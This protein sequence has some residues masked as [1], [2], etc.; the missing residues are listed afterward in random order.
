MSLPIIGIPVDVKTFGEAPFH[1]VGEKYIHAVAHGC[2]A[3]PLLIPAFGAGRELTALPPET[4]LATLLGRVDGLLLTGSPSNLA[5]VHHGGRVDDSGPLDPQRDATTLPLIR[6]AL[7][8]GVP[9]LA[10]CRGFQELNVALGGSLHARIHELPGMRDHRENPAL[11]RERQYAPVHPVRLTPGGVLARLI[12]ADEVAVNSLHGQGLDRLA[13]ALTIEA[14]APD[15]LVEAVSVRG[16]S[17]FAVG[18]QW[19]PEWRFQDDSLSRALFAALGE[20]ALRRARGRRQPTE[21]CP[22]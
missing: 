12:D 3:L 9:L 7:A 10:I 6:A 15:G 5:A 19:H 8:A 1:A 2:R 18:V 20:V 11:P 16:S 21:A 17:G 4:A 22:A 13:D 14:Q